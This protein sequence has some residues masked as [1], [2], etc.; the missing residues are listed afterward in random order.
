MNDGG[1]LIIEFMQPHGRIRPAAIPILAS[2]IGAPAADAPMEGR[3]GEATLKLVPVRR[4]HPWQATLE[5]AA[6]AQPGDS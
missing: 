5:G 6:P 1:T 4:G 2:L 3:M